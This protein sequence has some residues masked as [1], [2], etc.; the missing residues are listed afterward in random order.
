MPIIRAL[1]VVLV[2]RPVARFVFGFNALHKERLPNKGPAI[3]AANHNSHLDTLLL[4]SLFPIR[5]IR[6]IRPVAAA[7]YFVKPGFL[8]WF[9][10]HIIGILPLERRARARGTDPLQGCYDALACGGI[11]LL[12]P[13]GTRGEPEE[14]SALKTGI[15]H[16]V[17]RHPKVPVIPVFLQGAGRSLPKG[18]RLFV[19]FRCHA[20]IGLPIAWEGDRKTFMDALAL[21]FDELRRELPAAARN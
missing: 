5:L 1:F 3:I 10:K 19:P 9:S 4:A 8:G 15:V 17:R 16:I 2:C 20:S 14:L 13:E 12:F 21:A 18:H 7:D 11:L 6:R